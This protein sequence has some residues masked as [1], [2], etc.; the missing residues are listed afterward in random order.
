MTKMVYWRSRFGVGAVA[1][2]LVII[3]FASLAAFPRAYPTKPVDIETFVNQTIT[4]WQSEY[5]DHKHIKV[6]RIDVHFTPYPQNFVKGEGAVIAPVGLD[7]PL[8]QKILATATYP[9]AIRELPV[10][11]IKAMSWPYA[12]QCRTDLHYVALCLVR[13]KVVSH[14]ID[15]AASAPY[16]QLP[17]AF[18]SDALANA[19][20]LEEHSL[21]ECAA[22][23]DWP[24]S[25]AGDFPPMVQFKRIM[26]KVSAGIIDEKKTQDNSDDICAAMRKNRFTLHRAHVLAVMACRQLGIPSFAFTAA[27]QKESYIVGA[28][29]DPNGWIYYDLA[30]PQKGFFTDPPVLLTRA[31]LI[32]DFEGGQHGFWFANAAAYHHSPW[33]V[34]SFS[35]TDWGNVEED[36][37]ITLAQTYDLN[38]WSK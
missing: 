16:A 15:F 26:E 14:P 17:I 6:A 5:G 18:A 20:E 19:K 11:G 28:F 21:D 4:Q 33:G 13:Q 7:L 34:S 9:P 2:I 10:D 38:D 1:F 12:G 37:D 3:A 25:I 36:T 23:P 35:G 32:S 30:Q 29:S 31:P 8:G 24:K 27:T 22:F